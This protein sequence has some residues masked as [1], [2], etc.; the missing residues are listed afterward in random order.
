M[1]SR[2]GQRAVCRTDSKRQSCSGLPDALVAIHEKQGAQV[3]ITID[4]WNVSDLDGHPGVVITDTQLEDYMLHRKGRCSP[5][6][7]GPDA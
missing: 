2:R 5:K 3:Y 4:L 7:Q 1:R 6:S